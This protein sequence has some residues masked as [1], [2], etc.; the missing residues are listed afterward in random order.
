MFCLYY[1]W[2]L[3][4]Y[5]WRQMVVLHYTWEKAV[6]MLTFSQGVQWKWQIVKMLCFGIQLIHYLAD[7]LLVRYISASFQLK[8]YIVHWGQRSEARKMSIKVNCLMFLSY[9]RNVVLI[10][11]CS[12]MCSFC[13]ISVSLDIL[14]TNLFNSCLILV[15]WNR[16]IWLY[17]ISLYWSY[18][19]SI[20]L[21]SSDK[22]WGWQRF[23]DIQ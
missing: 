8:V 3:T 6:L 7:D 23:I 17:N 14:T 16:C 22:I 5:I 12:R 4:F 15:E 19:M 20:M 13:K 9:Y 1:N 11:T 21:P 10:M 2:S 18:N